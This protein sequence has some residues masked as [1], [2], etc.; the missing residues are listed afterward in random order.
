MPNMGEEESIPLLT[1]DGI[2]IHPI[3]NAI[4]VPSEYSIGLILL[5]I[6]LIL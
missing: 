2:H 3:D 4:P 1:G 6:F 5:T